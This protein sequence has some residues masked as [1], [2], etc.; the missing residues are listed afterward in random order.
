MVVL[1]I[2]ISLHYAHAT[3]QREETGESVIGNSKGPGKGI[4]EGD[5]HGDAL[6]QAVVNLSRLFTTARATLPRVT[7]M[8]LSTLLPISRIFSL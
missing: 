5:L 7:W 3:L 1:L 4:A 6:A 8:I 2:T